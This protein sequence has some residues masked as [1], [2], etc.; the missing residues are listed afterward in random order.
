MKDIKKNDLIDINYS[1]ENCD[2]LLY[3]S[4]LSVGIDI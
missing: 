4:T 2:V 1:L 3:N